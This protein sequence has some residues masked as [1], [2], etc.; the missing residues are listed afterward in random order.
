MLIDRICYLGTYL[1]LYLLQYLGT[2]P[3]YLILGKA[4][5][6]G[7]FSFL[8]FFFFIERPTYIPLPIAFSYCVMLQFDKI[9]RLVADLGTLYTSCLDRGTRRY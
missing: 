5:A 9:P 4:F 2:V 6:R 8:F 3:T 1:L 7:E